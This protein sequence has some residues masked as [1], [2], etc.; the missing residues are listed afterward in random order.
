MVPQG[1]TNHAWISLDLLE[2]LC[3]LA[4]RG[5]AKSVRQIL[6]SPL[7]QCPELLLLGIAQINVF[8]C[9]FFFFFHFFW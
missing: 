2:V 3:H 7:K 9:V 5:H 6:E 1:L 8:T 4:E